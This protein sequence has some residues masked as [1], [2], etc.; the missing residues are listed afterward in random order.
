MATFD[1]FRNKTLSEH[2]EFHE[3]KEAISIRKVCLTNGFLTSVLLIMTFIAF[4]ALKHFAI[5]QLSVANF[6]ILFFGVYFALENYSPT[7]KGE[8]IDYFEGF[9]VGLLTSVIAVGIHAL[10]FLIYSGLD[11]TLLNYFHESSFLKGL[12]HPFTLAAGILFEGMASGLIITYCLMQY[13]KKN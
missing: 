2:K 11:P 12:A 4:T 7:G 9:K 13:F 6:F 8:S 1:L 10:F 5:S 3:R